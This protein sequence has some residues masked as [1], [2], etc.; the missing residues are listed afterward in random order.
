MFLFNISAS[1]ELMKTLWLFGRHFSKLMENEYFVWH[2]V[3]TRILL[4]SIIVQRTKKLII[5]ILGFWDPIFPYKEEHYFLRKRCVLSIRSLSWKR[6]KKSLNYFVIFN[7][8]WGCKWTD[9]RD[10][11]HKTSFPFGIKNE[12]KSLEPYFV[13]RTKRTE[14][15]EPFSL[16]VQ[17]GS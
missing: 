5:I 1:I 13:S 3:D 8:E 16:G 15:I 11:I 10:W 12:K 7:E 14:F 9:E 6:L 2:A 17:E 4:R